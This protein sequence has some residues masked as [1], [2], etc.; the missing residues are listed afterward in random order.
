MIIMRFGSAPGQD[1]KAVRFLF[2]LLPVGFG[3]H[4]RPDGSMH[5]VGGV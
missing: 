2:Y 4:I 3:K 1:G 5:I